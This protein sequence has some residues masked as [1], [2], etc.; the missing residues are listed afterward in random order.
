M[1]S[2]LAPICPGATVAHLA[3]AG[4]RSRLQPPG[5]LQPQLHLAAVLYSWAA[6]RACG[7]S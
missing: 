3:Q 1:P 2:N 4:M 6:V 5:V 7:A